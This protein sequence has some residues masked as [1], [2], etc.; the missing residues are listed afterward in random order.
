MT[1][2]PA[3]PTPLGGGSSPEPE[4]FLSRQLSN[5]AYAELE[6]AER[7]APPGAADIGPPPDGGALMSMGQL[8]TYYRANQLKDYSKA[9]V[10]WIE[11]V[12]GTIVYIGS[13]AVGRYFDA[14]G[15]RQLIWTGTLLLTSALVA[16]AFCHA[17][18]Q[19]L[20]AHMLFGIGGTLCYSPST[21][22]SAHWFAKRRGTA[23]AVIITGAGAGGVIYPI[24]M[25]ELLDVLSFRNTMLIIAFFT[26][27][28]MVPP[29]LFMQSRLPPHQPP[30]LA[31]LA[32]P[33]KEVRY[34]CLVLGA[35]LFLVNLFTPY[36]FAPSYTQSNGVSANLVDYSIAIMQ[37]GS[38]AGRAA[39]GPLAD[40]FGVWTVFGTVTFA[41]AVVIFA[42]W[43]GAPG[44]GTA[45]A[46]LVLFGF[47]SGAWLTLLT[48]ATAA[49]S[50]VKEI[51]MRIGMLWTVG[52]IP[53]MVGPVICGVLIGAAGDKFMYAGVFTGCTFLLGGGLIMGPLAWQFVTR[54]TAK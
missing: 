30:P 2:R 6:I 49:I 43:T 36:F 37:A 32:H 48:A 17:Y 39:A 24:M 25:K 54:N 11:T 3:S 51:G 13:I 44:A 47:V 28:L 34:T 50:P 7:A 12:Q 10:A 40:K 16:V 33:W 46:G 9:T 14:H 31:T 21:S 45:I 15:P 4:G 19:F 18:Y 41:N 1:H 52:A 23:V 29:C 22:I 53:N 8:E 35:A 42:F 38:F 20:L 26:F 5:E 27:A